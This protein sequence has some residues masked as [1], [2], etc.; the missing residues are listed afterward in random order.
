MIST[1]LFS[2]YSCRRVVLCVLVGRLAKNCAKCILATTEMGAFFCLPLLGNLPKLRIQSLCFTIVMVNVKLS[3]ASSITLLE[4]S[5]KSI[6]NRFSHLQRI[7]TRFPA[8]LQDN[9]G[10]TIAVFGTQEGIKHLSEGG[11]LQKNLNHDG[12]GGKQRSL[13]TGKLSFFFELVVSDL[14]SIL[15]YRV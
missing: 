9:E 2:Y 10:M 13:P 3:Y 4:T 5:T 1:S 11:T 12:C 8:K 15:P 7:P 6:E 14:L